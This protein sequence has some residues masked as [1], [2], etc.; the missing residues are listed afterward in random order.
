MYA[1]LDGYDLRI[2][3]S[4]STSIFVAVLLAG[5]NHCNHKC[6]CHACCDK[7][8]NSH[9]IYTLQTGQGNLLIYRSISK[10]H[11]AQ[12][13]EAIIEY[14]EYTYR[15]LFRDLYHLDKVPQKAQ[16]QLLQQQQL[17]KA[18]SQFERTPTTKIEN[19]SDAE[20]EPSETSGQLD[21]P[22]TFMFLLNHSHGQKIN[23]DEIPLGKKRMKHTLVPF[24]ASTAPSEKKPMETIKSMLRIFPLRK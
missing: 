12:N 20:N 19:F 7:E 15:P 21:I 11:S 23:R 8:V 14:L 24:L 4:C 3:E 22:R 2:P 5:V 18:Q 13:R 16:Q 6:L 1:I 10:P 9:C 17:Q